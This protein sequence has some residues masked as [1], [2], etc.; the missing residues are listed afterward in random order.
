MKRRTF[1]QLLGSG[2]LALGS[3][4]RLLAANSGPGLHHWAWTRVFEDEKRSVWQRRFADF[5]EAG[6]RSLLLGGATEEACRLAAAEGLQVHAWTWTM[7]RGGKELLTNHPQWFV[8]NRDGVSASD[9]PP[10]VPYYHFLCPSRPEVRQ[11]LNEEFSRIAAAEGLTGVHLDY[12]RYP[13]VILPRALWKKYGLVQNE[14]LPAFDY[15]YCEACRDQ[16]KSL[17]G[18]DIEDIADPTQDE[19]WRHYRWNS[20]TTLVNQLSKTIRDQNK[21]ITAAVFPSP[22]IARRLVRQDWSRWNLDAVLPMVYQNFY[23]EDIAWIKASVQEG[24]QS[25][26]AGRPLYAGLYLPSFKDEGKF[27]QAVIAAIEGGAR[28]ISLFGGVRHLKS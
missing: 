19:S 15:C 13:D 21:M 8:V 18:Q 17:A 6:V 20:I 22:T 3:V 27:E 2:S 11:Y 4:G 5:R 12:I 14:E 1:L 28:G 9:N 24:V 26:P 10:Y 25:L 23:E 7:C 16:F